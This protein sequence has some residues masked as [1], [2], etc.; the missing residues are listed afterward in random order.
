MTSRTNPETRIEG[1]W[2]QGPK[3]PI[4]FVNQVSKEDDGQTRSEENVNIGMESK[5]N[6][7]EAKKAVC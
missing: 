2:P 6:L 7:T 3:L 5:S 4:V 1:F